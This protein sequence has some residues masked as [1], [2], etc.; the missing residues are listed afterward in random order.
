MKFSRMKFYGVLLVTA[1]FFVSAQAASISSTDIPAGSNW[2]IH[3]NLELIRNSEAGQQFIL[4]TVDEAL[5]DIKDDL[6]IDIA[7]EIH[8]V[9]IFGSELPLPKGA[10]IL[11]GAFSGDSQAQLLTVLEREGADVSTSFR[12]SL[13][14]YSVAKSDSNM[15]YT[16]EDGHV[17][18]V[19]FG[20]REPLYFSFAADQTLITHNEELLFDFL[21][22]G[23]HLG[24]LES[25]NPGAMLV[26]QADR[27]LLQGGADT[28][29]NFG[30][31]WD[32]SVLKNVDAF[33]LVV[34]ENNGGVDLNIELRAATEDVAMSVR[35]IVEGLV[36]LKALDDGDEIVGEILRSIRFE[37]DGA[38]LRVSVP[39]AADQL[40]ALKDL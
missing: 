33:A 21:D 28:S 18:D 14:Y 24:G 34:A 7:N 26:L 1:L 19:S 6:G 29:I 22:A 27:A 8:A 32:S 2:Y 5:G 38:V 23:G 3:A 16:T 11:H 13:A 17:E 31:K 20:N 30:G 4:D 10:V 39:V 25:A 12:G 9:T 35:N 37:N 36:A 15:T 40:E